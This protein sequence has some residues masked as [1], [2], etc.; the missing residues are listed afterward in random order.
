ME[1]AWC[2]I[3]PYADETAE[4]RA[5]TKAL[6]RMIESANAAFAE[7]AERHVRQSY[8]VQEQQARLDGIHS[9]LE[10]VFGEL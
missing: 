1:D 10:E 7:L 4:L 5:E 2:V 8:L 9:K 6:R 3:K